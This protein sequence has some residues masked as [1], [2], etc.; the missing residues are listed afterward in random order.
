MVKAAIN[1]AIV[2]ICQERGL[3]QENYEISSTLAVDLRRLVI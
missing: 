2:Q 3:N 1:I